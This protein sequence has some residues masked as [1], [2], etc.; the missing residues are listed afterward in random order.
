MCIRERVVGP[1]ALRTLLPGCS[2]PLPVEAE[3]REEALT[4]G[5]GPDGARR[6]Y[7]LPTPIATVMPP[8]SGILKLLRDLPFSSAAAAL[9]LRISG[10]W[11]E[12]P[13]I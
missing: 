11:S 3:P 12:L 13:S 10:H 6:A 2:A 7:V 5:P 1:S 4:P 8:N 9:R